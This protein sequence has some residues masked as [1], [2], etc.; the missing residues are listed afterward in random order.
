MKLIDKYLLRSFFVPFAYC[1]I[2]FAMIYI[3][4][5]LFNN[6]SDFIDAKTPILLVVKFYL[7][8]MP[9]VLIYIVPISLML[10]LLYSLSSLTRNNELTAMRASGVSLFRLMMPFIMVGFMA[11]LAVAV[12][13]ETLGPLSAYWTYQFVRQQHNKKDFSV[14]VVGP[15]GFVN[16][17]AGRDWMMN[18]YDTRDQVMYEVVVNQKNPDG[19]SRKYQ[20]QRGR[21]L[22][23]RWWFAEVIVQN[24]D[25]NGNPMGPPQFQVHREMMELTETPEVFLNELKDPEFLSASSIAAYLKT[26]PRLSKDKVARVR[27]DFHTRLAMP[28]T[29]LIV[30]MIGMPFSAQTGRK[31]AFIG[32]ML[33]IMCFFGYYVLV[34]VGL[35]MGKKMVVVPWVAGWMP[36]I[37]FLCVA[38]ILVR[39]MR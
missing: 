1:F 4:F 31:G 3:I 36:D 32:V 22:D 26:H 21:W 38:S 9:S 20:A 17:V 30:T 16:E 7:F 28:W 8:L 39:R 6:L 27:V 19:T 34:N 18:F 14:Y 12:I 35:A 13:N 29:C 5:D 37:F 33:A 23:G 25:R 15:F 2:G 10:A 24:Y 11:S